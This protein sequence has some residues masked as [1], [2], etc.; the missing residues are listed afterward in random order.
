[1]AQKVKLVG[2]KGNVEM[3]KASEKK[4]VGKVVAFSPNAY[5]IS[6]ISW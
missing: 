1:M 3:L 4:N 2:A 5:Q 6:V